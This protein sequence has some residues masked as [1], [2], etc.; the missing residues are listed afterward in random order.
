M[1]DIRP[2]A[3][4]AAMHSA[5]TT[6]AASMRRLAVVYSRPRPLR[7]QKPSSSSPPA[8][9]GKPILLRNSVAA[10]SDRRRR[11]GRLALEADLVEPLHL[12]RRARIDESR[13]QED[14]EQSEVEVHLIST[15]LNSSVDGTSAQS[16]L[17]R[18]LN[19]DDSPLQA[20]PHLPVTHI[21]PHHRPF[22]AARFVVGA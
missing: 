11:V 2:I 20:R 5:A 14:D 18:V 10:P 9:I 4:T 17:L 19:R 21:G 3:T 7:A 22:D 6:I 15:D 1:T 8:A 12:L 13:E 16:R